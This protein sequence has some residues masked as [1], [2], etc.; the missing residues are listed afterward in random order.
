MYFQES[1]TRGNTL[2]LHV[3]DVIFDRSLCHALTIILHKTILVATYLDVFL[4]TAD[5]QQPVQPHRCRIHCQRI[6]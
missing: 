1:T 3:A 4:R 2:Y 6:G 5:V